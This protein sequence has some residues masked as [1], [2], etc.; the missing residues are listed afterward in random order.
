MYTVPHADIS[1][2]SVV[3]TT[4]HTFRIPCKGTI[5]PMHEPQGASIFRGNAPTHPPG[6]TY[7]KGK[8]RV[9]AA[10]MFMNVVDIT[11]VQDDLPWVLQLY[12]L[13]W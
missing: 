5:Q 6:K 9:Q 8:N 2:G 10:Q 13:E 11:A 3:H 12:R 4:I 7:K 1:A